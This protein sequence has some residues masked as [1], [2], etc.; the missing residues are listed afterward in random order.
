MVSARRVRVQE[1]RKM[2]REE[3]VGCVAKMPLSLNGKRPG[4]P[5][6]E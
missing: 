1:A 6:T 4:S 2:E 5:P 3:K